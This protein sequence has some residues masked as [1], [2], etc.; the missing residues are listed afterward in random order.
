[1][2]TDGT[3]HT[4]HID[5]EQNIEGHPISIQTDRIRGVD[6]TIVKQDEKVL[7]KVNK[8]VWNNAFHEEH[9]DAILARII[10]HFG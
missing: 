10:A 8:D 3:S 9:R 1:M 4:N 7:L 6:F 2:R 5:V